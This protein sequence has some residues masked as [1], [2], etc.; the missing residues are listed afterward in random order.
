MLN[1]ITG[2]G[3]AFKKYLC[4]EVST[5]LHEIHQDF[6]KHARSLHLASLLSAPVIQG[7][8]IPGAQQVTELENIFKYKQVC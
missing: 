8:C 1:V 5:F 4:H 6:I 3:G 7:N 2:Q